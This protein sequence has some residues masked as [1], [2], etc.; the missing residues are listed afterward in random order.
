[1]LQPL[2]FAA[3]SALFGAPKFTPAPQPGN[4]EAVR[5]DPEW[6]RTHLVEAHVPQLARFGVQHAVTVHYLAKPALLAVWQAWENAGLLDLVHTWDGCWN[7]RY[8]RGRSGGAENL[9]N[10]AL[11]TAWDINARE[12]PLG[13]PVDERAPIRELVPIAEAYG[14]A[15]GG[16]FGGG[17]TDGMHFEVAKILP[18]A[19]YV[20]APPVRLS[21]AF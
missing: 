7:A 1:M 21:P 3:R 2:S 17:R 13:H 15:W 6:V 20:V 16:N 11:G 4:K 19:A 8:K 5:L 9:S 14:V 18:D 12:Y 10:H